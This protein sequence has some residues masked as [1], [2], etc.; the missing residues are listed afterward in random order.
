MS[1]LLAEH[2]WPEVKNLLQND[3][4]VIVPTGS[5]EQHGPHLPLLVDYELA[6]AVA[7][8]AAAEATA[9]GVTCLVTPPIWN[10]YSPHHM[11]FAG[12]ITLQASTFMAV[13]TDV[14]RS[15]SSHGFKRILFLNGH[16]GNTNLIR[17][18]VQTLEFEHGVSSAGANYWDLALEEIN[19]W[20][21]SETGGIN[22]A[23]EFETSMMLAL[24][25]ELVQLSAVQDRI[26]RRPSY[27]SP[28]LTVGG[29]VATADPFSKLTDTGVMG[30]PSL[31]SKQ[32][33][34]EVLTAVISAVARFLREFSEWEVG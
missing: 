7:R 24:R 21:Q 18:T 31:A 11:D 30:A 12:T 3:P 20:R 5:V 16:G 4:V 6:S 22:H 29:K 28:D 14:A 10:G 1:V 26:V 15:L 13:L 19:A 25:S 9:Q 34:D 23:C 32:R 17:T 33:G 27:L 2:T 8:L